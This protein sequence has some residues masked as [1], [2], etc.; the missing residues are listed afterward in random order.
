MA[1][2]AAKPPKGTEGDT[3]EEEKKPKVN[4]EEKN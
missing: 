3:L 2:Q 1:W 4:K